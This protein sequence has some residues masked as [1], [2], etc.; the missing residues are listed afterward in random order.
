MGA[1]VQVAA[2]GQHAPNPRLPRTV[3]LS[4]L[5]AQALPRGPW[6]S[7]AQSVT[8]QRCLSSHILTA[9]NS[10]HSFHVLSASVWGGQ[11]FREGGD[12][13]SRRV[14]KSIE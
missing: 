14:T 12:S 13:S 11:G 4:Y 9:L 7:R 1:E 5:P 10:T 8:S 2:S 3:P 6:W